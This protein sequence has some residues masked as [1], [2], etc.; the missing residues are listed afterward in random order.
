MA[1]LKERVVQW[2]KEAGVLRSQAW[3][4]KW[5]FLICEQHA[6]Q[7]GIVRGATDAPALGMTSLADLVAKFGGRR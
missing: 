5:P 1:T 7:Y 4:G 6:K 3:F 2:R